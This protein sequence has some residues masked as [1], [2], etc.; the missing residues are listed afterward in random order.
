VKSQFREFAALLS[1]AGLFTCAFAVPA[2]HA[3][4]QRARTTESEQLPTGLSITPT[5]ARGA[6]FETLNPELPKYP[7]FRAGEAVTTGLSPDGKTLLTLTS[8]YNLLN[9]SEGRRDTAASTEYVFVYDVS[10]AQP[11]KRQVLPIPNSFDGIVWNPSGA[12]FYVSGG[13]DDVV[14]VFGNSAGHWQRTG[15]PIPLGH[16]RGLGMA[17][18]GSADEAERKVFPVVSGIGI[19]AAGTQ[20]VVANFEN[21]SITVVDL[22]EKKVAAEL[23]LRPGKLDPKQSG[24]PGGEYPLWVVV[25]GDS[26]AYVSSPRDREI[27]VVDF[28]APPRVAARIPVHGQPNRMLL[29]RKQARLFVALGNT[30]RVAIIDTA[31][32]RV[33]EEFATAAPKAGFPDMSRLPGSNPNS[34]AL[35]PDERTLYVT[36]GGA[37]SVAV[38]RLSRD[39][40][41]APSE[42][43]GLIPTGWYPNSVS[44][45]RDGATLYV[46]NGKSNAGPN[47]KNCRNNT[48]TARDAKYGCYANNQYVMQLT[49]AGFLTLST[50]APDELKD[51]TVQVAHNNHVARATLS[52]EKQKVVAFLHEKIKHVI[53]I[54]KENRTYDQVLGDL[55]KGNGDPALAILGRQ[56]TPNHH[57]IA[58]QF[59]TLDNFFDSGE[60]SGNGWN[61][62]TAARTTDITE[63]TLPMNYGSR[64]I[65]YEFEGEN[66]NINVGFA[67]VQDRRAADPGTPDDPDLLPGTADVAAPDSPAGEAGTGY[68]WDSALRAGLTLRNYGFF[69]ALRR[70]D[71][72]KENPA[73]IPLT[74]DPHAE[75]LVVAYATKAALRPVTDPYFRGFDQKFPDYWRFKEWEREFDEYEK[76][77]NLPNLELVRLP[78]DHFGSFGQGIDGVGTVET[79]IADNDYAVGLVVEKIAHSRYKG[80]TLIFVLEDDAQ[81]GA[82][83]VDAHRSIALI[84]G[85]YVKQGAVVS[86]RFTTVHMLRTIEDILGIEYLGLNDGLAEPMTEVFQTES[87]DWTYAPLVPDVLRTT[88]LP[89]PARAS[90]DASSPSAPCLAD[91][92]PLRLRDAAYWASKTRGLNFAVEDDLDTERFNRV[93]WVGLRGE[94]VPYPS[95]RSRR[96][97]R[98]NREQLLKRFGLAGCAASGP[99]PGV[100]P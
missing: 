15:D 9:N 99:A 27:V 22:H 91:S 68:L 14:Y 85:P 51:L 45:S 41:H 92:A 42:V 19:N 43:V 24:T 18:P 48:S 94:K 59:V 50:P 39:P 49:R 11:V 30:D 23:D 66:R 90:N 84:A 2:I 31:S 86:H 6:K 72:P 97:L 57:Q 20:L 52:A 28:A 38:I 34:L 100:H 88:Q 56:L 16:A 67:T 80:D 40:A 93:V 69:L 3:A 44:V 26:R 63:K 79:E 76:Y 5:A 82:D 81:D 25:Q 74:R 29:D 4:P 47:V 95:T 55:E 77:G 10:G 17:L 60:V 54:V 53:Y 73:A 70:Y 1:I 8:G 65:A 12:E 89:L 75:N 64:G 46:V 58:R 78:H 7:A 98:D 83:H 37:N 13:K 71:L 96:N 87:S 36:N 33:I 32:A 21:D 35:S 61:W 62:S